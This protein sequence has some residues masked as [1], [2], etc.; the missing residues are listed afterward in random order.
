M[1]SALSKSTKRRIQQVLVIIALICGAIY[2][3]F[4]VVWMLSSSLK[5]NSEIF[6]YPPRLI[7]ASS[8]IAPYIAV[9]TDP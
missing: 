1:N 7:A 9:L 6:S 5:S 2:A 8:S 4:P 3:G